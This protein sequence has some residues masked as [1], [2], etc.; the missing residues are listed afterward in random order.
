MREAIVKISEPKAGR[1]LRRNDI[2]RWH[3]MN[4]GLTLKTLLRFRATP[5]TLDLN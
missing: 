2:C 1:I 4:V 5:H 3:P